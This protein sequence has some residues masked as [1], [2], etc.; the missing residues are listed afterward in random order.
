MEFN[1]WD[2][3]RVHLRLDAEF[4]DK[5]NKK[6]RLDFKSKE[7]FYLKFFN[8]GDVPCAT[9]KNLLKKSTMNN[10]F[11]PLEV[12][13]RVV[14]SLGIERK[15]LQRK[16]VSY[17]TGGGVNH[18]ESPILPVKVNPVFHMIFAHNV[19]DGT[20]IDPKHGRLPYFGYR[21]FNEF[22]RISYIRKLEFLFGKIFYKKEYSLT[23]P[24]VYSLP[25]IS[26][27]FF[28][29]YGLNNRGFMSETSRIPPIIF[30]E[31]KD[32]MLA[33]LI[34]FIIDEGHVDS[35]QIRI[36]LKNKLLIEDLSSICKLLGYEYTVTSGKGDYSDYGL[37]YILREG[38]KKLYFDY[39]CLYKTYP[40]IDLGWKGDKIRRSFEIINRPIQRTVGN[41]EFILSVLKNESLS[42]NQI[43]DRINMTRQGVRYHIH[44]LLK[45]DKIKLIN[46]ESLN[47]IYGAV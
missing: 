15:E 38:T 24:R 32:S 33:V 40:I 12:Y 9:F 47:W 35:T 10:F 11:A 4:L 36:G 31:G 5:L 20:V 13:L 18:I 42:V 37:L 41:R 21:Q 39:L 16:I 28:K 45:E 26:T 14:D 27:L 2:L 8:N 3:E 43:A 23:S 19:G 29:Y 7:K 1:I 17:K 44:S 25:V 46:D 22:Y 6:I 34:A 30:N